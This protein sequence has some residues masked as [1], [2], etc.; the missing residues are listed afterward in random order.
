MVAC[1]RHDGPRGDR[2]V[3]FPCALSVSAGTDRPIG[4][5]T[6]GLGMR[7]DIGLQGTAVRSGR[8]LILSRACQRPRTEEISF[9]STNG[10]LKTLLTSSTTVRA[11]GDQVR[12]YRARYV[13]FADFQEISQQLPRHEPEPGRRVKGCY[14]AEFSASPSV[15]NFLGLVDGLVQTPGQY[16]CPMSHL[17]LTPKALPPAQQCLTT[18]RSHLDETSR[19]SSTKKQARLITL[20]SRL[21]WEEAEVRAAL[22]RADSVA[23]AIES[24]RSADSCALRCA[25]II[26]ARRCR[27]SHRANT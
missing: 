19:S 25:V 14:R 24:E 7:E 20:P 18:A 3:C 4:L 8:S 1:D 5:A 2:T 12:F 13:I 11:K 17:R 27:L 10:T 21:G 15:R 6:F 26:H 9:S 22:S 16:Q 23:E